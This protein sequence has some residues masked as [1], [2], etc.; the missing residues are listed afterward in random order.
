MERK[1]KKTYKK[2]GTRRCGGG[3]SKNRKGAGHKGGRGNAGTGKRSKHKYNPALH[4][5]GSRGFK[6]P[7]NLKKEKPVINLRY[8]N[9]NL[10]TLLKEGVA[11]K[12]GSK[13][14]VDASKLGVSKVLGRGSLTK[15]FSVKAD[16]FSAKAKIKLEERGGEAINV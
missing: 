4:E 1:N 12:K 15:E 10:E 9:D 13:I 16:D 7:Q 3:S 5:V 8:L 14:V 11:F 6:R 2:R